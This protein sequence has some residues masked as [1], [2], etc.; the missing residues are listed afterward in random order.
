MPQLAAEIPW[1]HHR[2]VLDKIA[3]PFA[4][5]YYPKSAIDFRTQGQAGLMRPF[6]PLVRRGKRGIPQ[7][8]PIFSDFR[9]L[10]GSPGPETVTSR[11]KPAWSVLPIALPL[12]PEP[13]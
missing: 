2:L 12:W 10:I 5:L 7:A 1:W 11:R 13:A 6:L 4:S 3:D 9:P 8:M